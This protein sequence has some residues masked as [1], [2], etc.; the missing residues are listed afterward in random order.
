MSL[1][2]V[3]FL[4]QR[5]QEYDPDYELRKGTAFTELFIQPQA[6]MVQPLRD[7]AN[8]I[9]I[10]Q[11]LK[12]ILE[13]DDPDGFPEDA[14]DAIVENYYVFRKTGNKSGG[15]VRMLFQE[16]KDVNYIAET[17]QFTSV[18]G[19]VYFNRNNINISAQQMSS[20]LDQEFFFIDV[21]IE[22][23]L[24]GDSYDAAPN[25]I[26]AT[27]DPDAIRVFNS[28]VISG[29]VNR[30][31]NT[32][33]ITRA[34]QSIGERSLNTGKGA[35]AVFFET[36]GNQLNELQ[37]IGFGDPEMMRDILFNYHIGGRVD[38]WVKTPRI[39]EGFFD[40]VGLTLD[41]TRRLETSTNLVLEGT[42]E[43]SLGAI[44]I[45]T[46]ENP[47]RA[48]NIDQVDRPATF[49][50]YID[51]ENGVDLSSDQFIGIGIDDS[52]FKNVKISGAN[53]STT[54]ISEIVSSINV[55]LQIQVASI[56][57]NPI[58]VS[59]RRQGHTPS[60]TSTIFYDP[61]EN[62]FSN[63][64]AGD[65]L[66]ILVGDNAGDYVVQSKVSDNELVLDT[67]IPNE[68][69]NINY[70]VSRI[71]TYLRIQTQSRGV[72]SKILLGS[73]TAGT[74]A[75][76]DSLGLAPG[77]YEF[78][79]RGE[80]EYSEGLDFQV[81]T[82]EGTVKRVIGP[83]VLPSTNTG[84]VNK[85]IFFEDTTVDIFLNVDVGDTLTIINATT[86][87]LIGDY[88]IKGKV[89]N[90]RLRID[91]Y[92]P[93]AEASIEYRITRTGIKN[94]D[95]VKFTF[96]YNPLSIDIGNQVVLDELG[97]E[98][99]IRPGREDRTITDMALVYI[100]SVELIDPVSG[101]PTGDELEGKGGFGRGG[102]GRGGYG[103]GAL[104]QW[105][106]QVVKPELRFS[107]REDSYIVIATAFLGQSFRVNYRYV[108]E[109][110]SFQEFADSDSDR[111]LDADTLVKH[112][113]PAVVDVTIKYSTDPNNPNTPDAATVQEEIENYINLVPSGKPLDASDLTDL[114][115]SLIDPN[116]ERNVIVEQPI[117]M[118][119]TV[120]NT[121]ASLTIIE[122]TNRLQIP[123]EN[124]PSFT[125]S[126]LSPRTAHWIA[127]NIQVEATTVTL[128]GLA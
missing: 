98:T 47:I 4:V 63:V 116:R 49:I 59:R 111:V 62:I 1:P 114:V 3:D 110:V 65:I 122:N 19:N 55:A 29:G 54:Q 127:G 76:D 22:A 118:S 82:T 67:S 105:F 96:D 37:M 18:D 41:F 75:L 91:R 53:P 35:N 32:Q 42:Q 80:L 78:L 57:V 16:A 40:V 61:T 79:G 74:D 66:T 90:N 31:T 5:V 100:T 128:G 109:I 85:S 39:L 108:P 52:E 58:I 94:G 46:S 86:S 72:N 125:E 120:Y 8:D 89:N 6:L 64:A 87:D 56:A 84:F 81:D 119:A 45:D 70:R 103:R 17:L 12:R 30:E 69:Q 112:F 115:Y 117:Q 20:Q 93:V 121:D 60:D 124:I 9:F 15:I 68:E 51:L 21:E 2:I 28:N 7:E 44:S 107:S 23:E 104:A 99:G 27:S 88:K 83:T 73:P 95:L 10:N 14:V 113:I 24:E 36:F 43:E 38:A 34:Q 50:S 97:R 25:E 71:G 101:E 102:Y 92:I 123:E 26:I 11:S 77:T 48:F 106:H 126:P 13:L 33:Y